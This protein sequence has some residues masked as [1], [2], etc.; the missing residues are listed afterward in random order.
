[1]SKGLLQ[2]TI[3]SGTFVAPGANERVTLLN[4]GVPGSVIEMGVAKSFEECNN[5]ITPMIRK[6][7]EHPYPEQ[8]ITYNDPSGMA[9]QRQAGQQWV[10][11]FDVDTNVDNLFIL[12]GAQNAIMIT[13]LTLFE[14][15]D[16]IAVD[17]FAF[18]NF[19]ELSRLQR[20]SLVPIKGDAAGMLPS[21]LEAACKRHRIKGIF[22]VP[23][24]ANPTTIM[25]SQKRREDLAAVIQRNDLMLI[26]DDAD[27]F[28]T[29]GYTKKDLHSFHSMI[30]E[31]TIYICGTS[32]SICSGIRV[33]YLV[34]PERFVGKFKHTIF[35]ANVKT[36]S[37]E[38]EI[39]TQAILSGTADKIVQRKI[40]ISKKANAMFDKIFDSYYS[41]D[42][43]HTHPFPYFRWIPIKGVESPQAVA[44][45]LY[46]RGVNV[47]PSNLFLSDKNI[48]DKY[49]RV[50]LCSA[51]SFEA[52]EK[53]LGIIAKVIIM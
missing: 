7:A 46:A 14:P 50:S 35:N 42:K 40:E 26:E 20:I 1:M 27:A 33:A 9:H 3:G 8:F 49:L 22:Q 29:Y 15:G 23:S 41:P 4:E 47:F 30:P 38:G 43:R 31:S 10:S 48:K 51:G 5:M 24:C 36:S 53:G 25:M 19:M 21:E 13:L 28:M 45:H 12:T 39:V 17:S 37:L 16:R 52:F 32:K 44:A 18:S 11:K 34:T 6:V 2:T